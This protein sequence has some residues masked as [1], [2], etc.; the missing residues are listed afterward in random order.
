MKMLF[1]HHH[2]H[3]RH[4]HLQLE[5]VCHFHATCTC[6]H[7]AVAPPLAVAPLCTCTAAYTCAT[8]PLA[9]ATLALPPF[10]LALATRLLH[11]HQH[12]HLLHLHILGC[13]TPQVHGFRRKNAI[14]RENGGSG[15]LHLLQ[16][17]STLLK[18]DILEATK[19][20]PTPLNR[21]DTMKQNSGCQPW[22]TLRKKFCH[23]KKNKETKPSG[24][25]N[26]EHA[27]FPCFLWGEKLET[28]AENVQTF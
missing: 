14:R 28:Y 6:N 25:N 21:A 22:W 1:L 27:R 11:L 17:E 19:M 3:H 13:C 9:L 10:T 23:R 20:H 2:L 15:S 16:T 5:L 26:N 7:L 4:L 18:K 24:K 8:P 12:H